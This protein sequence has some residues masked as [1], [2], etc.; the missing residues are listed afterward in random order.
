M[1]TMLKTRKIYEGVSEKSGNSTPIYV[2]VINGKGDWG[3]GEFWSE[4]ENVVASDLGNF[5]KRYVEE[6]TGS[7]M[8]SPLYEGDAVWLFCPK[9]PCLTVGEWREAIDE[10]YRQWKASRRD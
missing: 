1:R 9:D 4:E 10:G 6:E 7:K 8:D 2:F 3:N 5:V